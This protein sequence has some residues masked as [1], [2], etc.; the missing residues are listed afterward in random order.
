MLFGKPAFTFPDHALVFLGL[1]G[2]G[3]SRPTSSA[4]ASLG[5][6]RKTR[7]AAAVEAATIRKAGGKSA[8]LIAVPWFKN[9]VISTTQA[10]MATPVES[11]SCCA[12]DG[13]AVARLIS[14]GSIS[15]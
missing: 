10:P 14:G 1:G 5:R 4:P 12:T 7:L 3:S 6:R 2:V 9:T 11:A 13:S 8:A 15:A